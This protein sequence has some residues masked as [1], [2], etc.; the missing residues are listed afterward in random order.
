M[1][2]ARS[3]SANRD[4]FFKEMGLLPGYREGGG[5]MNVEGAWGFGRKNHLA[6]ALRQNSILNLVKFDQTH[7]L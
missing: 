7:P 1:E 3:D 6:S 4:S 2:N 5:K